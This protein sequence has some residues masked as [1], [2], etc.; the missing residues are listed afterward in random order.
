MEFRH[1]IIKVDLHHSVLTDRRWP[2]I[3]IDNCMTV[4]A[5]KEKLYSNTGTHPAS[6]S[7]Y[8][9]RPGDMKRT[10]IH[11]DNDSCELHQYGVDDGYV[12]YILAAQHSHASA[13]AP[14]AGGAADCPLKVTNPRLHRHYAEQME[15]CRETGDESNFEA[16]RMSEEEYAQRGKGLREFISRM[17]EQCRARDA[18]T[19]HAPTKSIEVLRQEYPL[20]A[21]C[22]ISPSDLRGVVRFVGN[23]KRDILIGIELDEPMGNT[24]GSVDG[25]RYF[26]ARGPSYGIF[27]PYEQVTVGDFPEVDPFEMA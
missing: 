25:V 22:S 5:L 27:R 3:R 13:P 2:E 17:R 11:L 6:M 15:R 19:E 14:D 4:G 18:D 7:L 16:Y 10:Q 9:Y 12:I 1:R 21:R 24:D 8:A 26:T 23:V 20:G